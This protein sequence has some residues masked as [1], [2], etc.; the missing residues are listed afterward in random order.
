M[1]VEQ[2]M[3]FRN[4]DLMKQKVGAAGIRTARHAA[5]SSIAEVRAGAEQIG[6]PVIVK[7]ISGA[8]SMDTFRANDMAD[9]D[10]KLARVTSYE[11]E[12]YIIVRHP[13]TAV[14]EQAVSRIVS[15]IRVEL[16]ER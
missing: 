13:E 3:T 6:F 15:T 2:A 11:G 1:K 5:A 7:P 8:G 10:A 9:L 12:G 16:S 14:V 4:K